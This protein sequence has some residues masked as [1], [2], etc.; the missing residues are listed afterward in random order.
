MNP[1]LRSPVSGHGRDNGERVG[2][3]TA[4]VVLLDEVVGNE[5]NDEG[6]LARA[7]GSENANP[8]LP[9]LHRCGG[10]LNARTEPSG[11]APP[12]RSLTPGERHTDV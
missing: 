10:I 9:M 2:W 8:L 7:T 4:W 1:R 11:D 3:R 12:V 6:A 5:L